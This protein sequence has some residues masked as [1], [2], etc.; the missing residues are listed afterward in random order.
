MIERMKSILLSAHMGFFD[1]GCLFNQDSHRNRIS[2]LILTLSP[3]VFEKV[4]RHFR[5]CNRH[6]VTAE[7]TARLSRILT[8][9]VTV[10]MTVLM[11]G[12]KFL[13]PFPSPKF[14][15]VNTEHT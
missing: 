13:F 3:E 7:Y 9:L 15:V 10:L 2:H 11:T 4:T 6:A 1:K 8:V 12:Q 14:G 5:K